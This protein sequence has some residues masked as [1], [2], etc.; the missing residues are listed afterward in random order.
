MCITCAPSDVWVEGI[1]SCCLLWSP[2]ASRRFCLNDRSLLEI[3]KSTESVRALV[4]RAKL[5]VVL[6]CISI[7]QNQ[8]ACLMLAQCPLLSVDMMDRR[9]PCSS[10]N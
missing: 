4:R 8:I 9:H 1:F 7:V 5:S 6:Q 3:F 10:F 2:A